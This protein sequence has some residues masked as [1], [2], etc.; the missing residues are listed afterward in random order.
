M[1]NRIEEK[2]DKLILKALENPS[3]PSIQR[4]QVLISMRT[5]IA[6]IKNM[7]KR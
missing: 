6:H 3:S 4:A 1:D 7:E 5:E 2:L